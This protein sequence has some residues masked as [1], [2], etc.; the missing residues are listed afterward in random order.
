MKLRLFQQWEKRIDI[1]PVVEIS[2]TTQYIKV[3]RNYVEIEYC[4]KH[5]DV[6]DNN[7]HNI[8]SNNH[9]PSWITPASVQSSCDPDDSPSADD[10]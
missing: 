5:Q 10:V 7:P 8:L 1:H 6:L 9:L 4:A 3:L 2:N